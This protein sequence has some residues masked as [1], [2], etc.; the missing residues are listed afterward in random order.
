MSIKE[1]ILSLLKETSFR[2]VLVASSG[3]DRL[4][5]FGVMDVFAVSRSLGGKRT[6]SGMGCSGC[7]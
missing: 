4:F 2:N 3:A 7:F 6:Q 5:L 1:G